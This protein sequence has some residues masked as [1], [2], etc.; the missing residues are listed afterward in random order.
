MFRNSAG[1]S[2]IAVLWDQTFK[3]NTVKDVNVLPNSVPYGELFFK[4]DIDRILSD[5][6]K[7]VEPQEQYPDIEKTGH[8]T[9]VAIVAFGAGQD[10]N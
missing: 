2:K 3:S 5:I 10:L 4:E 8:G 1:N 9:Y 7:G 6:D